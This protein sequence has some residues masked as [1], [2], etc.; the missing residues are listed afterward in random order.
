VVGRIFKAAV[1][2]A[3]GCGHPGTAPAPN[4]TGRAHGYEPNARGGHV[5]G[6]QECPRERNLKMALPF[7]MARPEASRPAEQGFV[8]LHERIRALCQGD[9]D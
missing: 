6:I 9:A 5:G 7:E 4:Q 3:P 8:P 2:I 1:A